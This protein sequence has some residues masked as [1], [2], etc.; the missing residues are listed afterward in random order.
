MISDWILTIRF[1]LRTPS[2]PYALE[3]SSI[4]IEETVTDHYM[5]S[6]TCTSACYGLKMIS[7]WI[8]TIKFKLRTPSLPHTLEFSTVQTSA[9]LLKR[10]G[11]VITKSV[12]T[13]QQ[14]TTKET[15]LHV[16]PFM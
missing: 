4:E 10:K 8:L 11:F 13:S 12:T 6:Y 9:N 14:T 16:T 1:K 15:C 3:F 2:L 5:Y 7:D